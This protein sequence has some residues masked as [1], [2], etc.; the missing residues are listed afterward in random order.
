MVVSI[1]TGIV[2]GALIGCAIIGLCEIIA[3]A[4]ELL[5]K[6]LDQTGGIFMPRSELEKYVKKHPRLNRLKAVIDGNGKA[7]ACYLLS[8]NGRV[9]RFMTVDKQLDDEVDRKGYRFYRGDDKLYLRT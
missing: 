4:V 3:G 6:N 9:E 8:K 5:K 1:L 7:T 2:I